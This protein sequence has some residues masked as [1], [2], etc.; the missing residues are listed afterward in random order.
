MSFRW[1]NTSQRLSIFGRTGSGKTVL[2]AHVLS[3][4]PFH[5]QP[6]IIVDYKGDELLNSVDRIRT[7]ELNDKIPSRPGVYV[8]HPRPKTDDDLVEEFFRRV[9]AQENTGLFLDE[10]FMVPTKSGAIE[11]ILTQGRSL[12]IP[13][14]ALSQRPAWISRYFFS[15][16]DFFA[17]F[18]LNVADD[19]WKLRQITGDDMEERL[20]DYHSRYY[21]IGRYQMMILQPVPEPA[22]IQQVLHDRLRPETKRF[23]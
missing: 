6:Y 17:V 16:A 22:V 2:G 15:E 5:L 13:V 19:R 9:W 14:I 10:T 20:P 11:G 18:H 8:I 3:V 4:A 1:P 23:R 12:H 21:D 7:L